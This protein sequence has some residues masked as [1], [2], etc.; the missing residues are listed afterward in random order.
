MLVDEVMSKNTEVVTSTASV[1]EVANRMAELKA[2]LM[3]IYE[4][5]KLIGTV[6]DRDLVIEAI[7]K[8]KNLDDEIASIAS[9]PV[10]YCF[11]GDDTE[12]VLNNMRKN[13]VQRLVVLDNQESKRLVGIV[14]VADIA[15]RCDSNET[16]KSIVDCCKHYH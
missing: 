1:K 7:A 4:G 6:T 10:L 14:S 8:G 9:E 11:K 5:D 15:S 2:G 13:E 12:T 16:A 3:P